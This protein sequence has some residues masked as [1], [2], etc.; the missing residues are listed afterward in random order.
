MLD[1]RVPSILLALIVTNCQAAFGP[2]NANY[3]E[4][5]ARM[6]LNLAAAAYSTNP[7]GCLQRTFPV[8]EGQRVLKTFSENCDFLGN[9]CSGYIVVSDVLRQITFVFRGTKTNSQ[10]LLEGWTT[11]QPKTEFY[12]IGNVNNYFKRGHELT[13]KYIEEV[14]N[15]TRYQNY[16]VYITG[17]SLGGALAA[18][19]AARTVRGEYRQG[20]QI[21]LVTFGEPRVGNLQFSRFFDMFIPFSFRIVHAI[22]IV[23]HLPACVKDLSYVPRAEDNGSMP[24]DPVSTSGGYHHGLEIWY[25]DGMERGAQYRVCTGAPKNEDFTCSNAPKIDLDDTSRGV[26]DH[27]NY[28]GVAVPAFGKGSCDPTMSFDPPPTETGPLSLISAIFGRKK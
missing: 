6:L 11:L 13:W 8:Q 18:L 14:Y 25:P 20:N 4:T 19:A 28:F 9:P 17:H 26:W 5:E 1:F 12:G 23:P 16:D 15:D 7:D 24:C 10:L 22:D 21:K 27:R 2:Q 3:N